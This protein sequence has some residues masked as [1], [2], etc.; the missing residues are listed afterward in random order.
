LLQIR[1]PGSFLFF[2]FVSLKN[3]KNPYGVAPE[4][5]FMNL[6]DFLEGARFYR[7]GPT[8]AEQ[9]KL[10]EERYRGAQA[11]W[12][13]NHDEW[14]K[15]QPKRDP[16][17]DV[18]IRACDRR[19]EAEYDAFT[20]ETKAAK[21]AAEARQ[22]FLRCKRWQLEQHWGSPPWTEERQRDWNLKPSDKVKRATAQR[23]DWKCQNCDCEYD[24]NVSWRISNRDFN[25]G[26]HHVSYWGVDPE[27]N[28]MYPIS[29]LETPE[30]LRWLCPRCHDRLHRRYGPLTG[31]VDR[32]SWRARGQERAYDSIL[33]GFSRRPLGEPFYL[34]VL[35]AKRT[36][37][38]A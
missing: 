8:M 17:D 23:A 12:S 2:S 15:A 9:E 31:D 5:K 34:G 32:L 38:D 19:W 22:H 33:E 37:P 10:A 4:E 3:L 26:C 1:T 11:I 13:I 29:T 25:W 27:Y 30:D 35:A 6:R 21:E 16:I 14:W 28:D 18:I 36:V 20:R 24:P 7:E